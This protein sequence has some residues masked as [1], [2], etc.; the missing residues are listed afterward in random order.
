MG[1]SAYGRLGELD[2]LHY[3]KR[4]S[5]TLIVEPGVPSCARSAVDAQ[6]AAIWEV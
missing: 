5:L 4:S 6:R 1:T 2:V 3:C